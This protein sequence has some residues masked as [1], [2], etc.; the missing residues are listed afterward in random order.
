MSRRAEIVVLAVI[1]LAA[2]ILI[3]TTQPLD[4]FWGS[5]SGNRFIQLQSFLRTGGVAIDRAPHIGHHFVAVRGKGYSFYDPIF[6]LASAPFYTALGLSGLFVLPIAGTLLL[7]ALL[8][9]L[10]SA[11]PLRVGLLV[12]FATPIFWYTVVFWEHTIAAGLAIA[13]VALA[14]RQRF[15]AT[16]LLAGASTLFREEGYIVIASIAVALLVI[17]RPLREAF[18]FVFAAA[19]TLIPLW[20]VN[21]KVFGHPAGLHA[22]VYESIAS[23]GKLSNFFVYL[24]EFTRVQPWAIILAAPAILLIVVAAVSLDDRI[25]VAL[26]VLAALA[27]CVST[28][29]LFRAPNPLHE[30]LYLQGL[31]LAIPFS[32]AMFVAV[33][34]LWNTQ[35]FVLVTVVTGVVLTTLALNQADVGVVW[36]PRHYLWLV[37]LIIVLAVDAVIVLIQRSAPSIRAIL[38]ATAGVLVLTSFADQSFGLRILRE[39]LQFS[40]RVLQAVRSSPAPVVVTDVFWIPEDLA[41]AFYEK[42]FVFVSDDAQLGKALGGRSFLFIASHEFRRISNRAFAPMMPRVSRRVRVVEPDLGLDVMLLEVRSP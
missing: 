7:I 37:P 6:P 8:P 5:D 36:G 25:R 15:I 3:L 39:K 41:A 18:L 32:I 27:S 29:F 2:A 16:G 20:I 30:T 19:L 31:F 12:V 9:L 23:G 13:A 38:I 33:R 24:F 1:V 4:V 14:K 26:F 17:R 35:R 21:W 10:T 11:S 42:T 28:V 40:E 34:E 22:L